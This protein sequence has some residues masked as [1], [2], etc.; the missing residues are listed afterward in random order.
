MSTHVI[1]AIFK[2][3][4]VSYFANPLGYLFILV[5]VVLGA[6]GAFWSP[7]FFSLNLANLDQLTAVFPWIMLV[8]VPAITMG[9]W[10][11]ERREGTDELLLTAPASDREVVT[12]KYLAAVG[13]FT[14]SLLFSLVCNYLVLISL[15][16]PDGGLFL[17]TYFGYWLVGIA[18]L[19]VGMAASFLTANLTIA[20]ILGAL[21]NVPLVG[22][23]YAEAFMNPGT[24]LAVKA[25]SFGE[26]LRDFASGV[27]TL[28]GVVYFA[29]IVVVMLYLSMVLIG[30]RHWWGGWSGAAGWKAA[31]HYAARFMALVV[32]ATALV[33]LV[34]RFD[35]RADT[36][37]ERTASLARE[38]RQ[39]IRGIDFT[40]P[41]QIEAFV[42]PAV[43]EIYAQTRLNLLNTLREL[44]ALG[45][46]NIEVRE[47]ATE[48]L[49]EA[50]ELAERRYGITPRRVTATVRGTITQEPIFLGVAVTS[51]TNEVILPFID[52]GIP[53]EYELVRSIATV[54][55]QE[56]RRL[57]VLQTDA[58]L[59]G[60]FDMQTMTPGQPWPIIA[61]L[62]KQYEVV[63]V[64]PSE[65]ITEQYDVLLAVQPSSLGPEELEHFVD[66][67]AGGQPTAI[68]EDP[69]PAF[70]PVPGTSMPRRAPQQM[71]MFGMQQPPPK[72][73]INRLWRLLG[74]T[75]NDAQI[76]AQAYNPYPMVGGLNEEFVF[77]DDDLAD[78]EVRHPFNPESRISAGL[79]QLL[80]PYPGSL[81][82]QYAA[83]ANT[84]FTPLVQTG[85]NTFAVQLNDLMQMGP[86]GQLNP[87]PRRIPTSTP[88]VLAAHVRSAAPN[89]GAENGADGAEVNAVV[90]ADIDALS[91]QLFLLREQGDIPELGLHFNF[92]NV[93]FV[94][95]VLD[96]L[97]GDD[98]F[99][100]LR[101]R[102]P[103]YR[104]LT[105]LEEHTSDAR[106]AADRTREALHEKFEQAEQ[107]ERDA[108]AKRIADLQEREFADE[109][110]MIREVAMARGEW[111]RRLEIRLEQLA[112]ERDRELTAIE[113]ELTRQ[114]RR[115]QDRYKML[116]VVLPSLPLLFVGMVV[117]I[118]R[119]VR[120]TEGV[121][122]SRLR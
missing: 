42:S 7:R 14:A 98:R 63:R 46:G 118:S 103:R 122:R 109:L 66:A 19:A 27:V 91:R 71:A 99:L 116:A 81:I 2:R 96:K 92:D 60:G 73:D 39:L 4:F 57:G 69:F 26:R 120:E 107:Q 18:M 87:N 119:K 54:T 21:F 93:P 89:P 75:F 83:E 52:R 114:V 51:G 113:R 84:D 101:V 38:T 82:R 45:G 80:F 49:S 35:L 77:I 72:G 88:Y 115:V 43:P 64:D 9:I 76:V 5:F 16:S 11:E 28:A 17:S 100:E 10:A 55:E 117:F 3:N 95:N 1:Y 94:L 56:Q 50:A 58:D 32:T 8:F 47:N 59:F 12:G 110:Q 41:V 23:I 90:V 29:A 61:E 79:Q 25:W 53:V 6:I 31:G 112:Q 111:E 30:R 65:P 86:V 70:V 78:D 13:I 104:T 36:T 33:F 37:A 85:T 20:Y 67:V 22:L 108:F 74:L 15:G 121:S 97:A 34:Q 105:R 40:R 68:F 106:R 24:A 62:E 48:P 44:A 102:R